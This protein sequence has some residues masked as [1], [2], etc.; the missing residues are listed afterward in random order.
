MEREPLT[1]AELFRILA[2]QKRI[3]A[4]VVLIFTITSIIVSLSLPKYY[5]ATTVILPFS[6]EGTALLS[7]GVISSLGMFGLQNTQIDVS[8][9][10]AILKSR[11]LLEI[12][13]KR[14]NLQKRYG[15]RSWV[16]TLNSL[17]KNIKVVV[18]E[19]SQI[20]ITVYDKDQLLVDDVANFIV[21]CLDSINIS[22]TTKSARENRIFI[23]GRLRE[24]IDSLSIYE[25]RLTKFMRENGI[26]SLE[27]QVKV[28][29]EKIADLKAQLAMKEI[30]LEIARNT[31]GVNSPIS[32]QVEIQMLSIKRKYDEFRNTSLTDDLF[33][34]FSKVPEL[35]VK[36]ARLKREAEYYSKLLEY[37]GPQ[38]EQ[39][40]INEVKKVS[41]IQVLD[42]AVTP[43]RKAKPKRAKIVSLTFVIS[44]LFGM[45]LAY[46]KDRLEVYRKSKEE[47]EK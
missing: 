22:L 2:R 31:Y 27:E 17:K 41:T 42:K 13:A 16:G 8:R 28:G 11:T 33:P 18:G 7:Q 5:K 36:F 46:F 26:V 30:E 4:I 6:S 40:K 29:V 3:V 21:E 32:R 20:K 38:Y 25:K 47:K 9:I 10:L 45:Y 1:I 19:E 39:A 24:V 35:E 37:L 15:K 44:L 12:V 23:E 43:E 14:F 34:A